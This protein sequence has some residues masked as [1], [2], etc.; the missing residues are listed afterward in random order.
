MTQETLYKLAGYMGRNAIVHL[1]NE[2][3]VTGQVVGVIAANFNTEESEVF[4]KTTDDRVE[5]YRIYEPG[6]S[7]ARISVQETGKID[8]RLLEQEELENPHI[9][10]L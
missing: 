7:S 3:Q 10:I 4:V 1:L 2:A 5:K 6:Y 8:E 9:E